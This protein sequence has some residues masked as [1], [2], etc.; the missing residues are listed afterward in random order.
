MVRLRSPNDSGVHEKTTGIMQS[1]HRDGTV[2][3]STTVSSTFKETL[4]EDTF[5]APLFHTS[6]VRLLGWFT[7]SREGASESGTMSG[8]G[9]LRAMKKSS[10]AKKPP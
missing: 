7:A 9:V 2:F 5:T 8:T 3:V 1:A 6:A 10:T 4:K